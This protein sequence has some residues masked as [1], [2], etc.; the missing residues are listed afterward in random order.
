MSVARRNTLILENK[1]FF[2]K[3]FIFELT[4]FSDQATDRLY[5]KHVLG[6]SFD[7]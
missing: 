5:T 4:C 1:P 7:L 2:Y 6:Q 3:I